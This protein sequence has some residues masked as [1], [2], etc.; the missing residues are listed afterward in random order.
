MF[1][2]VTSSLSDLPRP[3]KAR[4]FLFGQKIQRILMKLVR[5]R[6]KTAVDAF[7]KRA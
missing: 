1:S 6:V 7:V 2:I 4:F 3:K 5:F